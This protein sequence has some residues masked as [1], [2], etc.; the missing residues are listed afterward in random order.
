[1]LSKREMILKDLN[2]IGRAELVG[3]VLFYIDLVDS[4]IGRFNL[5]VFE[6]NK[7]M[8]EEAKKRDAEVITVIKRGE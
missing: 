4:M 3:S 7:L 6:V 1:M 5:N 8:G 2:S